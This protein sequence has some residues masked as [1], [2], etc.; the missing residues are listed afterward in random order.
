MTTTNDFPAVQYLLNSVFS[1]SQHEKEIQQIT[2]ER[3]NLF[4]IVR[5]GHYEVGTHSPMLA[6][7]LNPNGRH[8]QGSRFLE[9]FIEA[10]SAKKVETS[11]AMSRMCIPLT[12][13][14]DPKRATVQMERSLGELGRVDIL[15]S[16]NSDKK[17]LI[18]EN[19]I[20]A[21]D[22]KD[23]ISRYLDEPSN[24]VVVYLTLDGRLPSNFSIGKEGGLSEEQS[25][26]LVCLSYESDVINWLEAC[27]R[28]VPTVAQ[29]RESLT[30]YIQLI[31]SLTGQ[32]QSNRMNQQIAN[33]I[34]ANNETLEAYFMLLESK[35][36]VYDVL[37]RK[38]NDEVSSSIRPGW[39]LEEKL[40]TD[41]SKWTQ[42]SISHPYLTRI[43]LRIGLAFDAADYKQCFLGFHAIDYTNN[44]PQVPETLKN[45]FAKK[46][47]PGGA[48]NHWPIWAWWDPVIW[49]NSVWIDIRSGSLSRKIA[50]T[51]NAIA[52]IVES[53][54]HF[55]PLSVSEPPTPITP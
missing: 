53:S 32:N 8:G 44:P 41:G 9:L 40:K 27:R 34:N 24:P 50:E 43:G 45:A 12:D 22:Q 18:I 39:K 36:A 7:L 54:L 23:Q 6:E 48:T 19:K 5:I 37:I 31:K 13:F 20:Y 52:E 28:E 14:P 35:Q 3:F 30:Q 26:R 47:R 46:F 11:S 4:D 10:I 1:L 15:I 21:K 55:S 17:K 16:D 42:Y 2:G 25:K 51:L 33:I 38:L 49:D 29:V